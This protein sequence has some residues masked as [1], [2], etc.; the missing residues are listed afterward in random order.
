MSFNPA[1]FDLISV[2]GSAPAPE[3]PTTISGL[4][5]WFKADAI[6]TEDDLDDSGN[7]EIWR[8]QSGNGRD[9]T[10]DTQASRPA[11][12]S[13]DSVGNINGLPTVHFNTGTKVLASGANNILRNKNGWTAVAAYRYSTSSG[14]NSPVFAVSTGGSSDN[15]RAAIGVS[16]PNT[17]GRVLWRRLD[18]DSLSQA[19]RASALVND[20]LYHHFGRLD[21][22]A[23]SASS[24]LR[25]N[26]VSTSGSA[27]STGL[28]SDTDSLQIT[29]GRIAALQFYG[30][31]GEI[32]LYDRAISDAE[33]GQ[34]E[35]YLV[36]RWGAYT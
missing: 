36:G 6:N 1:I 10:Q 28:I 20:G 25:L 12:I 29:V 15:A 24:L 22:Q 34:I 31:I 32:L 18:A 4:A 11:Y 3:V 16:S 7:V 26:G 5:M 13:F 27:P 8:D 2:A 9:V 19:T 30:H 33:I 23:S 14:I 35:T 17:T 21:F